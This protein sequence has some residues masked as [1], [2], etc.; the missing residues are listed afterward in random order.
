MLCDNH[1]II[2]YWLKKRISKFT[3]L[4]YSI[5]WE[6]IVK[7]VL[8]QTLYHS[9]L[10]E[11]KGKQDNK[12]YVLEVLIFWNRTVKFVLWQLLYHNLLTEKSDNKLHVFQHSFFWEHAVSANVKKILFK[13]HIIL[14]GNFTWS[15]LIILLEDLIRWKKCL[16]IFLIYPCAGELE[17]KISLVIIKNS[18]VSV[19]HPILGRSVHT[20]CYIYNSLAHKIY[21]LFIY[22]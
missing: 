3:F 16:E 1:F 2:I 17:M 20:G 10:T 7:F 14:L 9:L 4:K 8:W 21:V 6:R 12:I 22:M 18:C 13:H 19:T 11:K 5:F 15:S